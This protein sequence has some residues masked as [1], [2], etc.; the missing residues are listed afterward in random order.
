MQW[1]AQ[2]LGDPRRLDELC[3]TPSELRAGRMAIAR[4]PDL[5]VQIAAGG[6]PNSTLTSMTL[7][8]LMRSAQFVKCSRG[9][10]VV[11]RLWAH[12]LA[13]LEPKVGGVVEL[14]AWPGGSE[15]LEQPMLE[16]A[17]LVMVHGGD[18]TVTDVRRR[19]PP[20]KRL[21]A[22]GHK[23]SFGFVSE[24]ALSSYMARRTAERAAQDVAAWDQLGC[25]SPHLFYVEEG[26]VVS[27]E[28][29][30]EQLAQAL[31]AEETAAPRGR[32][33]D[34]AAAAIKQR[35]DLHH[36]RG[37]HFEVQHRDA[38]TAPR[39]AFF[40]PP[41]GAT[42]VWS[43]EGSSAWTV[44]FEDDPRFRTSCLHRFV[45]VKPCGNLMEA[46]RHADV[47][48]EKTGVVGIGAGEG[49]ATQLAQALTAWG[50]PRICPIGR[51]QDPPA[52]WRHDG[53]PA[54]GDLV[55]WTDWEQ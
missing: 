46:L 41:R 26:G 31:A 16:E 19:M 53:R 12:S 2:D 22:Y 18:E 9:A 11:P 42:R 8:V 52:G 23:I 15:A 24:D 10:S 49:R 54:L 47:V 21:A 25:L 13:D 51:M 14:A 44:V 36:L 38:T 39:G 4:A 5:L 29:F 27:P 17:E 33:D 45:Y 6:L 3:G 43:S 30:A 55:N 48:R 50:V 28:G 1:V 37:V 34:A 40:E 35:R 32:I 7:G 20:G